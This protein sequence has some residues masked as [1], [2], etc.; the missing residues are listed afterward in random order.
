MVEQTDEVFKEFVL[1]TA[2][3]MRESD[4]ARLD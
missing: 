1:N 2:M 3:A 4:Y